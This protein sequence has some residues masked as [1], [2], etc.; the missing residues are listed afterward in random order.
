M[1]A[2][3]ELSEIDQVMDNLSQTIPQM[4]DKLIPELELFTGKKAKKLPSSSELDVAVK[5]LR[6]LGVVLRQ[7]EELKG[8]E[9]TPK[10][11]AQVISLLNRMVRL[12]VPRIP[13][14]AEPLDHVIEFVHRMSALPTIGRLPE[15]LDYTKKHWSLRDFVRSLV[16]SVDEAPVSN[17][18]QEAFAGH[19]LVPQFQKIFSRIYLPKDL[20]KLG[21]KNSMRS[22]EKLKVGLR[23]VTADWEV[24]INLLYGLVSLKA[25]KPAT[26][27][28]IRSEVSLWDKVH[29]VLTEPLLNPLAK[30]EWVTVRNALDHGFAFFDPNTNVIRFQDLRREVSWETYEA[31][32]QGIDIYLSNCAMMHTWSFVT[33]ERNRLFEDMVNRLR[34]LSRQD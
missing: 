23:T 20:Q 7:L 18:L 22:I 13:R 34:E 25:G 11:A 5:K 16:Q 32:L 12:M 9:L 4:F 21:P 29:K 24:L 15:E 6:K 19:Y 30:L 3:R 26:W 2:K 31:W 10:V 27:V 1:E 8:R 33:V 14:R 17:F 28:K